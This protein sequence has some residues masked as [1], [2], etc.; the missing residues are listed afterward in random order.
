MSFWNWLLGMEK[1][2]RPLDYPYP[3]PKPAKCISANYD[4]ETKIMTCVFDNGVTKQYKLTTSLATSMNMVTHIQ[5]RM[6]FKD[7]CRYE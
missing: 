3:F 1:Q 7:T 4:K 6:N 2:E 5:Q